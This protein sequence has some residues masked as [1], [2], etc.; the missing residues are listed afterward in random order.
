MTNHTISSNTDI[1]T[2]NNTVTWVNGDT[3]TINTDITFTIDEPNIS[4]RINKYLYTHTVSGILLLD[5]TS[6]REMDYDGGTLSA[7]PTL[8]D[9]I[10]GGTSGATGTVVF[11]NS[12]AS[13]VSGNMLIK[14]ISGQFEDNETLT[15]TT[16]TGSALANGNGVSGT[17]TTADATGTTLT[18]STATFITRGVKEGEYI[19]NTTDGSIGKITNVDSETQLTCEVL[20]GGTGNDFGLSDAYKISADR[21]GWIQYAS[22]DD[23]SGNTIVGVGTLKVTGEWYSLGR[24]TGLAS[25]TF[26]HYTSD[27]VP[28]VEIETS[29]GSGV[30][31]VWLNASRSGLT[32]V[33]IGDTGRF[34]VSIT[35]S[36][37]LTFG[38]GVNGEIPPTNANVRVPNV[39]WSQADTTSWPAIKMHATYYYR[40]SVAIQNLDLDTFSGGSLYMNTQ[41]ST[42]V[43]QKL[44]NCKIFNSGFSQRVLIN[45]PIQST[46]IDGCY[47]GS[48]DPAATNNNISSVFGGF[49]R[50]TMTSI[51]KFYSSGYYSS[52][53]VPISNCNNATLTNIKFFKQT[54]G[55]TGYY[56]FVFSS[57][58]NTKIIGLTLVGAL[59]SLTSCPGCSFENIKFSCEPTG[60]K[61][62]SSGAYGI[63]FDG[64]S[65]E[66]FILKGYEYTNPGAPSYLGDINI[67]SGFGTGLVIR[68]IGS[69]STPIDLDTHAPFIVRLSGNFQ[70]PLV[71]R[72]YVKNNRVTS[73]Y[74]PIAFYTYGAARSPQTYNCATY[75]D[76]LANVGFQRVYS[77]TT[78]RGIRTN[79]LNYGA[80]NYDLDNYSLPDDTIFYDGF[81]SDTTGVV[82]FTQGSVLELTAY[83][84]FTGSV[85]FTGGSS[86]DQFSSSG[87]TITWECPSIV[88]GHT[89][90]T[91]YTVGGSI[92]SYST[93]DYQIDT[94]SGWSSWKTL[95]TTNLTSETISSSTGFK[96]KVRLTSTTSSTKSLNY[97]EIQTT[98]T[99]ADQ[100]DNTVDIDT[101]DLTLT[102]VLSGS[103]YRIEKNID[104]T[105]LASGTATADQVVKVN[106][107]TGAVMDILIGKDQYKRFV[108]SAIAASLGVESF[109]SQISDT[110][111]TVSD[112]VANAYTGIAINGT[113]KTVTITT[114]HTH[115]ELYDY[116]KA[117]AIQTNNLQYDVPLTTVDGVTFNQT[118]GWSIII[119]GSGKL[120]SITTDVDGTITVS[121]GGF[122]EGVS[123]VKWENT[124]SVYYASH[125]WTNIKDNSSNLDLQNCIIAYVETDTD[126]DQTYNT[127]LVKGGL[128][129]DVNGN[130]EGY[131]VYKVDT[132]TYSGHKEIVG[133]YNYVW[134][135]IP[136]SF[137]G[138][139]VG[140]PSSYNGVRLNVDSHISKTKANALL[141]SGI[142]TNHTT[143]TLD[144]S[145]NVYQDVYDN[146]KARQTRVADIETGKAGYMSFYSVGLILSYDGTFYSLIDTWI[147]QN[148]GGT[149]TLKNGTA[150][151]GTAGTISFDFQDVDLDYT[152]IGTFDHRGRVMGGTITFD[153]TSGGNV[154]AQIDA[155]VVYVNNG[156][157]ITVEQGTISTGIN[158]TGLISGS[159]VYV[160]A[161]GTQTVKTFIESSGTSYLWSE[162]WVSD[163]TVDYTIINEGYL[164]VRVTGV[165]AST[166]IQT[167][168]IN[169][170]VDRAYQ[171]SSG[172]T[173]GTTA[174]VNT[175]TKIFGL[176]VTSTVQNWYSFMMESWRSES[177]LKNVQF[178]L[179][180]NGPNSFTLKEYEWDA[181]SSINNL[182]SDGMR[183][184]DA[185]DVL[186][187]SWCGILSIG[188][189]TGL[190][191]KYQQQDGL[192]TT[193]ALTTGPINQLI[194]I[195]GDA[196]HGNFD[197]TGHM[198]LK[199]QEDGY[200]QADSD[201]VNIFGT[202]EDQFYVTG[203]LPLSNGL[204]TGDPS[205]TG[206]TIT[207]HG[208]SPV[209]WNGKS[210][211][212][213]IT[214]SATA[215]T[216][217]EIM[218]WIRYNLSLGGTFQGKDA[219]NWHDLVQI[220]GSK[221]KTVRGEIYGDIGATIKGVR[222]VQNDGTTAHLDFSKFEADDGTFYVPPVILPA[223]ISSLVAGSRV[224]VYNVTTSTEVFNDIVAG[225]TYSVNY[226]EGVD[227]TAGDTVRIRVAYVSGTTAKEGWNTNVIATS[228]GWST[229][230]AQV[231][232]DVYNTN[233]VDGSL[234]TKFTADYISD[235][236]DLSADSN[237][238]SQE[239]YAFYMYSVFTAPGIEQFYGGVEAIDTGNYKI[240]TSV[241]NL[242]FDNTTTA[243]HRQTDSA[244][245]FRDDG[246]YPVKD[247][248]TSA[249]GIDVN[250]MTPVNV[251]E[252]NTGSA[253][254]KTT[255]KDALTEQGYTTTRAPK[256]D[257]IDKAL[258]TSKF[259]ALK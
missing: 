203:L 83:K 173:F 152:V 40:V 92:N 155:G 246:T 76:T 197:Y 156:P 87:A 118:S 163:Q 157:N 245:I 54:R 77:K 74:V 100:R 42:A 64:G 19:L 84:T 17:V 170:I 62:T 135:S 7:V 59:V 114:A 95:N 106:T 101:F 63:L 39:H 34:F 94:G 143:S 252:V 32:T 105:L 248:T 259:I 186:T 204:T 20:T 161:T 247:P 144:A 151:L 89:G 31:E 29:A 117:W 258:T 179:S 207:D 235:E 18:D 256:I 215:H 24:S 223:T 73:P 199:I 212:I 178:P 69:Y 240:L 202:L 218:R 1:N 71:A 139:Q 236:I 172:L 13:T 165:V 21:R 255:V 11:L 30:Y 38:D 61:K 121:S 4:S 112:I 233:A 171:S 66:N 86:G 180:A 225:T 221:F 154:T 227:Y 153:N 174:T 158:F 211:S 128:L 140:T 56:G 160:F 142:T 3:I 113:A 201:L 65:F 125:F 12:T 104:G 217:T 133:E 195:Y 58:R 206:V 238:T 37:T 26:T 251:V 164:P 167:I 22:K 220:D 232:D 219:F 8:G 242:Y 127:S 132:T 191:I 230:A 216:G 134:S 16:P 209:T 35:G 36:S 249:F 169:Q 126:S 55:G 51:N 239:A 185:S 168:P 254:N 193:N 45:D 52:A 108:T 120:T 10:T 23:T 6:I 166:S 177:T 123:G 44:Y 102:G 49:S 150:E 226:T 244:R 97:V 119:S 222:V 72:V 124:G 205:V 129:S 46:N 81:K 82:S 253:V 229:V 25:Q 138:G 15:F 182:T 110:F 214:D 175:T 188:D 48:P 198:V 237:F 234:I 78:P 131:V 145:S 70:D 67:S 50:G 162:T 88:Y 27:Y 2:F 99:L 146:L 9:T 257:D 33:G 60:I 47:V 141:V 130:V 68:D 53:Q 75:H 183:Y 176:T 189:V 208:A 194:Q 200:D 159:Q 91:G 250:W 224:Q 103:N 243:S 136:K 41:T 148:I 231:D 149:G 80:G 107:T 115:Q 116:C 241:L 14:G 147:I 181:T 90:L 228:S 187:A 43:S 85:I 210:F 111:R 122:Y 93:K 109:I 196:T 190:Q 192:N 98:T 213:T 96:L 28:F 79:F 184:T 57:N 137:N 5:G